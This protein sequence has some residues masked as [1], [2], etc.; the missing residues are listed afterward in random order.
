MQCTATAR[1]PILCDVDADGDADCV[2]LGVK[3]SHRDRACSVNVRTNC[4]HA[5]GTRTPSFKDHGT[6]STATSTT[7]TSKTPSEKSKRKRSRPNT[8]TAPCRDTNDCQCASS[9]QLCTH[10]PSLPAP[11][12]LAPQGSM[13]GRLSMN[14]GAFRHFVRTLPPK[15]TVDLADVPPIVV[16]D[17]G[18]LHASRVM[19]PHGMTTAERFLA[20]MG[21]AGPFDDLPAVPVHAPLPPPPPCTKQGPPPGARLCHPLHE[22]PTKGPLPTIHDLCCETILDQARHTYATCGPVATA[23]AVAD[24]A[25]VLASDGTP[26]DVAL[27]VCGN[28]LVTRAVALGMLTL[29]E[30]RSDIDSVYTCVAWTITPR[31]SVGI[32]ERRAETER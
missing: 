25:T 6:T 11:R 21:I 18:R 29:G 2:I 24:M 13:T 4:T 17:H 7:A 3:P 22:S 16:M 10:T 8:T 20:R 15:A 9:E 1:D 32:Y 5:D 30:S 19:F 12:P 23:N 26:V 28:T 27:Y 31:A 14:V